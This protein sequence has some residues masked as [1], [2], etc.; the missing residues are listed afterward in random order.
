M[1]NSKV[2]AYKETALK[3]NPHLV[4]VKMSGYYQIKNGAGHSVSDW[5]ISEDEAWKSVC[6]CFE[7]VSEEESNHVADV[8]KM[9]LLEDA[10]EKYIKNKFGDGA[11]HDMPQYSKAAYLAGANHILQSGEYV[12][13]SDVERIVNSNWCPCNNDLCDTN[14][15]IN[16]ILTTLKNKQ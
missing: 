12:K 16:S 8:G 13:V 10:A 2:K 6:S 15:V 11:G 1:E 4:A 5:F 3:I 7:V 14:I 9:I